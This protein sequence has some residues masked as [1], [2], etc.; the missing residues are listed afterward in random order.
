MNSFK[1]TSTRSQSVQPR[2]IF[3]RLEGEH[4][5]P[6]SVLTDSRVVGVEDTTDNPD[7]PCEPGM[8]GNATVVTEIV[9]GNSKV[10]FGVKT[11]FALST[12]LLLT[13]ASLVAS[14]VVQGEFSPLVRFTMIIFRPFVHAASHH[15]V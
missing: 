11:T 2:S 13:L 1:K 9:R 4:P 5:L 10:R 14:T 8:S 7:Q 12:G 15:D 6:R 3:T